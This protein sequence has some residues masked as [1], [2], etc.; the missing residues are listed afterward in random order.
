MVQLPPIFK[1][2]INYPGFEINVELLVMKEYLK[3]LQKGISAVCDLYITSE[4]KNYRDSEYDEYKHIYLIAE[5]EIP[6]IIRI[7]L[8]VSVYTIYENSITQLLHY[9]KEKESK[10]LSIKDIN[11][12]SITSTFNKYMKHILNYEFQISNRQMEKINALTKI[13]NC[14]AH[15][16]GNIESIGIEKVKE[17][18]ALEGS[19]YE[20]IIESNKIDVSY[21]FLENSI[22]DVEE[23]IKGLMSFMEQRYGAK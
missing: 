4:V 2:G 15:A 18:R 13:R 12:K 11:G 22:N 10:G 9:A 14:V 6:R 1:M 19:E 16:N 7:P 17:L 20:I 23:I 3:Q 5:E 8:V 21:E